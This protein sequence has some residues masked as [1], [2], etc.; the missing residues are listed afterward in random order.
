HAI[1]TLIRRAARD[2]RTQDLIE[3]LL[4]SGVEVEL[5]QDVIP[6]WRSTGRGGHDGLYIPRFEPS[7]RSRA[8]RRK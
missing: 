6:S 7:P 4:Q 1:E 5:L 3:R 8:N 2:P